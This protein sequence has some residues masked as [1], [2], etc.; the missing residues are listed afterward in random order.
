MGGGGTGASSPAERN[1]GLLDNIH[2]LQD[3]MSCLATIDTPTIAAIHGACIGGGVDLIAACDIRFASID[4]QFS[5]RET[6]MAIVA[7][8]G[9][10]QRLQR[11][12]GH[13][14]VNELAL[15][16]KDIGAERALAIG[17]LNGLAESPEAALAMAH[18]C[19]EEIAANSPLVV[20]GTKRVLRDSADRPI[21]E[22]LELVAQWNALYLRSKDLDEAIGAFLEKRTPKFEGR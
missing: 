9:S 14:M 15:T 7:D 5:V 11:I 10:L 18:A 3:A 8:L 19:A 1:A 17:L 22:G 16:G 6:K 12:L 2:A 13:G 21:D 20:R 4:A